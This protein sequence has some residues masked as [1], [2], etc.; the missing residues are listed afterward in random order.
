VISCYIQRQGVERIIAQ[1]D[2]VDKSVKLA[3]ETHL[4]NVSAVTNTINIKVVSDCR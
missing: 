2:M 3:M 4:I 1:S